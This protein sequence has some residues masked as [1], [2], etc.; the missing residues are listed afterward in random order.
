M[1]TITHD[2]GQLLARL[3]RKYIRKVEAAESRRRTRDIRNWLA[4][5]NGAPIRYI[6][7][8]IIDSRHFQQT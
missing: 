4:S 8:D 3:E 5:M 1:T 7:D 2:S 6:V